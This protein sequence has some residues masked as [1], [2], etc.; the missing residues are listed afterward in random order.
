M[1]EGSHIWS[2]LPKI[3]NSSRTWLQSSARTLLRVRQM[4]DY[5]P[6]LLAEYPFL[7]LMVSS[8]QGVATSHSWVMNT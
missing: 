2:P 1:K 7:M 4:S 5:R 6:T 3:S 8:V